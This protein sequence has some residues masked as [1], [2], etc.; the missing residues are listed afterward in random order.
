MSK[1]AIC[2]SS[3]GRGFPISL[4]RGV[5]PQRGHLLDHRLP[6]LHG[7]RKGTN[8]VSTNGV[9]ANFMFLTGTFW[10]SPLTYVDLPKSAR[11]YLFPDLSKL[12]IVEAPLVLTHL[13]ATKVV[14]IVG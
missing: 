6:G 14:M 5:L 13:S 9:A 10:A 12:T 1:L 2:G 7:P 8:G 4:V 3:W 11:A